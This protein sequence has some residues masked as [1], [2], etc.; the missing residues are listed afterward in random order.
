[1]VLESIWPMTLLA[2]PL[3][4]RVLLTSE[5]NIRL[6]IT[7]IVLSNKYIF[8]GFFS[9]DATLD[10]LNNTGMNKTHQQSGT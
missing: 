9:F 7:L 2:S 6:A 10:T 8:S 5:R 3:V 1:M 4:L